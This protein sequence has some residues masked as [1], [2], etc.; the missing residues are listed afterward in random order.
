MSLLPLWRFRW[1]LS[2]LLLQRN[3]VRRW[4]D[5]LM[6][7]RSISLVELWGGRSLS[8]EQLRQSSSFVLLDDNTY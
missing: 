7:R 3:R 5:Q 8:A 4:C 2:D 6:L 1:P